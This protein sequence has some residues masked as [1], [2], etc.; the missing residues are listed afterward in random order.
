VP[1]RRT[2]GQLGFTLATLVGTFSH[3]IVEISARSQGQPGVSTQVTLDCM[4][5]GVIAFVLAAGAAV[6]TDGVPIG[7]AVGN[8]IAGFLRS[9]VFAI[10]AVLAFLVVWFGLEALGW[11]PAS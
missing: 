4:K 11:V 6:L 2:L 5:L 7:K 9:Q 3:L 10:G 1:K 8:G